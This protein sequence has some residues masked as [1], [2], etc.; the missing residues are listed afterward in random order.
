MWHRPS[1]LSHPTNR[2]FPRP[3]LSRFSLCLPPLSAAPPVPL[4]H[5]DMAPRAFGRTPLSP[6][7]GISH[8]LPLLP[9]RSDEGGSHAKP[10]RHP[11]G[12]THRT[13]PDPPG[14]VMA[15][16]PSDAPPTLNPPFFTRGNLT[17]GRWFKEYPI[18]V[19]PASIGIGSGRSSFGTTLRPASQISTRPPHFTA[20]VAG[21]PRARPTVSVNPRLPP[22]S[23]VESSAPAYAGQVLY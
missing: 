9:T 7:R 1:L 21:A 16:S 23:P 6:R 14:R 2:P 8:D 3:T 11:T 18:R 12:P 22:H 10:A 13:Q 4:R 17:P 15:P 20:A 5:D 19:H